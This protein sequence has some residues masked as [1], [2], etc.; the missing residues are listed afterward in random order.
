MSQQQKCL[1]SK[2]LDVSFLYSAGC[3]ISKVSAFCVWAENGDHIVS[4]A[5]HSSS[6]HNNANVTSP[7]QT[8]DC[9]PPRLETPQFDTSSLPVSQLSGKTKSD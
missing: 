1:S 4:V 3:G 9:K 7:D 5:T 8:A 2:I 6:S